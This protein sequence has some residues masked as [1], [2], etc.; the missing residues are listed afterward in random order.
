MSRWSE[1]YEH[2]EKGRRNVS[3]A[4]NANHSADTGCQERER[5]NYA[6]HVLSAPPP[7]RTIDGLT[8][9]GGALLDFRSEALASVVELSGSV[10]ITIESEVVGSA[11]KY[12]FS[13]K[14]LR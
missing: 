1:E 4:A 12:G 5:E 14:L 10:S 9:L 3:P 6:K 11:L 2:G 13:G 8:S 7:I